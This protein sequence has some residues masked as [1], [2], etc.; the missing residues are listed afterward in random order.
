MTAGKLRRRI[1]RLE[2]RVV[3]LE[4]AATGSV[5]SGEM[6]ADLMRN[7]LRVNPYHSLLKRDIPLVT[8]P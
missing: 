2:R 1:R 3:V 6:A 7:Q 8:K 4:R 5:I